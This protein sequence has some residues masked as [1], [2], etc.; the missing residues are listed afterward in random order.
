MEGIGVV[1]FYNQSFSHIIR[2]VISMILGKDNLAI[3]K[4]TQLGYME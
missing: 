3:W 2:E 1:Y 4:K